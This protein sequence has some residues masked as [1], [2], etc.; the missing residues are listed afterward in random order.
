MGRFVKTAGYGGQKH[1]L[2]DEFAELVV[3]GMP[4]FHHLACSITGCLFTPGQARQ[5]SGYQLKNLCVATIL[6]IIIRYLGL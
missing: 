3:D 5:R 2:L 6:C 1:R 4:I